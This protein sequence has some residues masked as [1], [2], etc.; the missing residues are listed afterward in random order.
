MHCKLTRTTAY[1]LIC[2]SSYRRLCNTQHSHIDFL[3]LTCLMLWAL[4]SGRI[5]LNSEN[6]G[7]RRQQHY[8]INFN[9]LYWK[10]HIPCEGAPR[11]LRT[12]SP[13]YN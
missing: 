11:D 13:K 2:P 9:Q 8:S 7:L 4:S 3:G 10:P 1:R 5:K 12:Q 6:V